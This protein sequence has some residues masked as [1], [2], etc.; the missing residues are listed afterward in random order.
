MR[1][2]LVFDHVLAAADAYF[3]FPAAQDGILPAAANF[4]LTRRPGAA[5]IPPGDPGTPD[6]GK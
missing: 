2:L 1:P 4:R 6:R 5:A 3:S